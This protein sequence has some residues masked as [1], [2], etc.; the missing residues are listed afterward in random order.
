METAGRA[1]EAEDIL[2][3]DQD[4]SGESDEEDDL[5]AVTGEPVS[6]RQ[7]REA[8]AEGER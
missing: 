8:A 1:I 3:Q 2:G 7:I 6:K 4:I 5:M